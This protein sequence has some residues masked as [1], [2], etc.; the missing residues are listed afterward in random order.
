MTEWP[1]WRGSPPAGVRVEHRRECWRATS[2]ALVVHETATWLEMAEWLLTW[3]Y[4]AKNE[5]EWH[6][7]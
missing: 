3:R 6:H 2:L 1:E 5:R 7:A 4:T